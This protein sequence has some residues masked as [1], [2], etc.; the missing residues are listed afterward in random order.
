MRRRKA[1]R[2]S[3]LHNNPLIQYEFVI[4]GLD[5]AIHGTAQSVKNR[6]AACYLH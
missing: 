5:P 1:L 3:S 6:C 4:A 2:F